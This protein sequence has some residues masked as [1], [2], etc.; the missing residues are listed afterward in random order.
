MICRIMKAAKNEWLNVQYNSIDND[1]IWG[2]HSKRA[3]NKLK[4][5]TN[6]KPWQMNIIEYING[7]AYRL[8]MIIPE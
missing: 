5:I 1:L 6:S 3:F 4:S 8:L 2:I 7:I